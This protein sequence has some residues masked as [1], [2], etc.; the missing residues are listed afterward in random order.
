MDRQAVESDRIA[1]PPLHRKAL[2]KISA[3]SVGLVEDNPHTAAACGLQ[4]H[5]SRAGKEIEE[6]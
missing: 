1:Q 3:L 5:L 4:A 6:G 2:D